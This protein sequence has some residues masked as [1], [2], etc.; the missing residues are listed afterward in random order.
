MDL[1]WSGFLALLST[2]NG[3]AA[4]VG[5][6]LSYVAEY[7]PKYG[8]LDGKWKRLVFL[9]SSLVVPL[10]AA[11]LGILTAGWAVSW[12][13]VFWPALLAGFIAFGGGTVAH[14]RKL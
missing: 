12:E 10:A 11:G 8:D 2:P 9:G 6:L 4:A 13:T 1:S 7:V 3:I 5:V 14:V